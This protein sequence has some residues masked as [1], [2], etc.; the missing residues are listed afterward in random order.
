MTAMLLQGLD[1][2]PASRLEP[3]APLSAAPQLVLTPALVPLAPLPQA[4]APLLQVVFPSLEALAP[5]LQAPAA[6]LQVVTPSLVAPVLLLQAPAPPPADAN[7]IFGGPNALLQAPV[8]QQASALHPPSD[9][10]A[11]LSPPAGLASGPNSVQPAANP[12]AGP[13]GLFGTAP[14]G[15]HPMAQPG[16]APPHQFWAPS[17]WLF[18]PPG[19][20]LSNTPITAST[21]GH[22]VGTSQP[23]MIA[24]AQAAAKDE[25]VDWVSLSTAEVV[26]QMLKKFEACK[27]EWRREVR[28]EVQQEVGSLQDQL[29]HAGKCI[30][31]LQVQ[32][33]CL[34]GLVGSSS[35]HTGTHITELMG[36]C[37]RLW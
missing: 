31:T 35:P 13:S 25:E 24:A 26:Q 11:T 3:P 18:A 37:G 10:P 19:A 20:P 6:P 17:P 36:K 12:P 21:L 2:D 1:L 16:A 8:L 22:P 4:P 23:E 29:A 7:P 15:S 28:Q 30:A 5:M 34:E 32:V 33:K 27:M 9:P 14:V